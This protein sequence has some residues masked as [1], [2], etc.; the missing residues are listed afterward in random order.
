MLVVIYFD[1]AEV[2]VNAIRGK[3]KLSEVKFEP[4]FCNLYIN[5]ITAGEMSFAESC[6]KLQV[7][8][9]I[10]MDSFMRL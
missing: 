1:F 5:P 6:C 7:C 8:S 3:S 4:K 10:I 2:V 9:M